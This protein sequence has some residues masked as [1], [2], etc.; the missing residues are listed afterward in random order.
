MALTSI[1]C[2]LFGG[3]DRAHDLVSLDQRGSRWF[4][5]LANCSDNHMEKTFVFADVLIE[6]EQILLPLGEEL[7]YPLPLIGADSYACAELGY[8]RFCFNFGDFEVAFTAQW[9][10]KDEPSTTDKIPS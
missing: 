8:Y 5:K 9:P 2:H 4:M 7:E 6:Y 10:C 3:H 1:E